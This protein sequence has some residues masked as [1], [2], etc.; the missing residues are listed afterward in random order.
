[1]KWNVND[2]LKLKNLR[3]KEQPVHSST[4]PLVPWRTRCV[5]DLVVLFWPKHSQFE[6]AASRAGGL[7]L[8]SFCAAR[9][10]VRDKPTSEASDPPG[11]A[12]SNVGKDVAEPAAPATQESECRKQINGNGNILW[13]QMHRSRGIAQ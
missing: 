4:S 10:Y 2:V 12:G 3:V 11:G 8:N 13:T 5:W 6:A 7:G 1:M 9:L